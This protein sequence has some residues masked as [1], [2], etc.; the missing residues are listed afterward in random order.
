MSANPFPS[1][2]INGQETSR[3]H[4]NWENGRIAGFEEALQAF[5]KNLNLLEELMDHGATTE[6]II[7]RL[8]EA[9]K[10]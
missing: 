9:A 1:R 4:I 10:G 3:D 6:I 8:T 5:N 2:I 7:D